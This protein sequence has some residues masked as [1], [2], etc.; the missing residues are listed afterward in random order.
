MGLRSFLVL[1]RRMGL[2]SALFV[3]ILSVTGLLLH[4]S[5]SMGLDRSPVDSPFLLAWYGIETPEEALAYRVDDATVVQIGQ[6]LFLNDQQLAGSYSPLFGMVAAP[7]GF[8]VATESTLLLLTPDGEFIERLGSQHGVP[9]PVNGLAG[10][11]QQYWLRSESQIYSV[12]IDSLRFELAESAQ[13]AWAEAVSVPESLRTTLARRYAA[14]LL[15]WE[16]VV[17]DLHSGQLFG[18]A[19]RVLMDI[20]A[21]LFILM[22]LTG[23]WIWSKR[24]P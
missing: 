4:Y 13:P 15:T 17:L 22:A 11:G 24:R 14:S 6:T 21:L 23:I 20:M 19:G 8:L 9:T 2:I 3:L 18:A 5:N 10:D 16:R 12:D 1:H 7:F